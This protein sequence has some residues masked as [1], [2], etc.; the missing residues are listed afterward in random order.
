M[1]IT[2][3]TTSTYFKSYWNLTYE[4]V[5]FSLIF[6][7]YQSLF[8]TLG[9]SIFGGDKTRPTKWDQDWEWS[10]PGEQNDLYST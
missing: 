9:P 1:V 2:Q 10:Q 8:P 7:H 3:Q 6:S 4:A 5:P